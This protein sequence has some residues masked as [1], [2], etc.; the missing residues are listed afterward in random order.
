MSSLALHLVQRAG[1]EIKTVEYTIDAEIGTAYETVVTPASGKKLCILDVTFTPLN[2]TTLAYLGLASGAANPSI[3]IV[4]GFK[5]LN[6][7]QSVP[8][9]LSS[10]PAI[11]GVDWL[12]RGGVAAAANTCDVVVHYVELPNG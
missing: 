7:V 4:S 5:C 9:N 6:V 11:G 10:A 12:L 8:V 1:G 3:W 2:T